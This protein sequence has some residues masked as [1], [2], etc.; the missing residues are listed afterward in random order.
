MSN[1]GLLELE[2]EVCLKKCVKI[3]HG[4]KFCQKNV[5]KCFSKD[6]AEARVL[7]KKKKQ[8]PL[9]YLCQKEKL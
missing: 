8:T 4:R 3:K 1:T 6:I 9:I 2:R 7:P 5:Y